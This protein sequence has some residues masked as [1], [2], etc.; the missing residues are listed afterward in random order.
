MKVRTGVDCI[1][2]FIGT[3]MLLCVFGVA[4]HAA[5]KGSNRQTFLLREYKF[6]E[7]QIA[8][9]NVNSPGYQRLTK[10]ALRRDSLILSSDKSPVDVV[11][12]RTEALLDNLSAMKNCPEM[13]RENELLAALRKKAGHGNQREL[14]QEI[15]SLRRRIAFKNPLL[16]FERIVFLKHHKQGRGEVHMVDQ[17]L[18]FNA[19]KGG[20]VYVLENAFSESPVVRD[21]LADSMVTQGRLKGRKLN[22]GSFISLELGYDADT[23]LFAYTEAKYDVP[24]DASWNDQRWTAQDRFKKKICQHYHFRPESTYHIFKAAIDGSGL[25][26]LTDGSVNQYDPCFL[27]DDRIVYIAETGGS[28]RCGVRPLPTATLHSMLPDG[29]DQF[30]LSWHDTNE[31]HPSIDNNGLIVYTRW[32]YIDRDSDIAHHLWYCYPD[33]RDPRSM[34]GNY[35][36]VRESRPWMELSI[37]AIPGSDKYIA[38]AAPHHGQSYGSLVMINHKIPDDR[39]MSQV[40]RIT[41]EVHFPESESS[42]G[43]AHSRGRHKPRGEVY[44]SPWP[45]SEDFYLCV[46][47]SGQRNYAVCL[48]DSF[49]NR[50]MLYQDENIPCLDPIPLKARKRPPVIPIRTNQAKADC[51]N[52][53]KG[54]VAVMNVYEAEFPMPKETVVKE[55]RIVAVF[56][57]WN[58]FL[59]VPRIGVAGQSLARGVLGTVPVEKDGSSYFECPTNVEIYFQALD[60]KGQAV[61]TMRSG[62]YVHPGEHLSC[63]GCHENK[64]RPPANRGRSPMA[65]QRAPSKIKS[66]A[67]GSYPLTFP[68]LVQPVLDKYCASCHKGEKRAP[69]LSGV[70]K[71][72]VAGEKKRNFFG[73]SE[74][75]WTLKDYAWGKSGGNGAIWKNRLSYSL[76]GKIG[77]KESKL[78]QILEKGH[79][80]LKIA[81]EDLRRITLW[82]D[83]NS[84]FYGAYRDIEKQSAGE[85]VMPKVDTVRNLPANLPR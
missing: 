52:S 43:V 84:V 41:P 80:G 17:Y 73:W 28:Q 14:F 44:G 72:A 49:G 6:L 64:Y 68:R 83:C 13:R 74:S 23:L 34:H 18:G 51:G 47:D 30:P 29:S 3:F 55:L 19:R 85:I 59:D 16:D 32:D 22:D 27:P 65:L 33:G 38:V 71:V 7:K 37:R 1:R 75:Y 20:G 36:H 39:A 58:A 66:E 70:T 2:F 77:A 25:E 56:P 76:P 79:N 61:Q 10:E 21:L 12:R 26:Q 8:E 82:L 35:P 78:L 63:L 24:D 15:C 67:T 46:Y 60:E 11:L 69:S 45:L 54:T 50:I 31:W 5:G 57:K 62:T 53:Q 40:R 81:Q 42:P 48:V 9:L 4:V